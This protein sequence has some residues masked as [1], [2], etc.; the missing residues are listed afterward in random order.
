M[1]PLLPETQTE[2]EGVMIQIETKFTKMN[3]KR[4]CAREEQWTSSGRVEL[5][6]RAG[7]VG[8]GK[9]ECCL[10]DLLHL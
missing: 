5:R 8:V 7:H 6:L 9:G 10:A 1:L 2:S 3:N 4:R